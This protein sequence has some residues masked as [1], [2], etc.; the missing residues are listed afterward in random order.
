MASRTKPRTNPNSI[1]RSKHAENQ[2]V[3]TIHKRNNDLRPRE[4]GARGF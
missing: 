2:V 4:L 3:S 1:E